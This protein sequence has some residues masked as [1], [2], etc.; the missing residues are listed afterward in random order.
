MSG[1]FPPLD[2]GR[3]DAG[4]Y[5]PWEGA[6]V[7]GHPAR[8]VPIIRDGQTREFLWVPAQLFGPSGD[9]R[10]VIYDAALAYAW[11]SE[12]DAY[13]RWKPT[14]A[15]KR[16]AAVSNTVIDFLVTSVW[17]TA[18]LSAAVVGFFVCAI[19]AYLT[20]TQEPYETANRFNYPVGIAAWMIW[21]V[22]M[23][24]A[25]RLLSRKVRGDD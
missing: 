12:F 8:L 17:I 20:A 2:M 7:D 19:V 18:I 6:M 5:A 11:A 24:F 23:F 10:P 25:A 1:T 4:A 13:I 22:L 16:T 9:R 15:A 21:V 14:P 3:C